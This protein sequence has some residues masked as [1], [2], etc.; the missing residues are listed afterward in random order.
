MKTESVEFAEDRAVFYGADSTVGYL[1]L[2][3]VVV[4][5]ALGVAWL[6]PGPW[7]ELWSP[8]TRGSWGIR[9]SL[10]LTALVALT[11]C[12][13]VVLGGWFGDLRRRH[14]IEID[15]AALEVRV[16]EWW[17]AEEVK[18][19]FPF[20]IFDEFAV[21]TPV[22][23][24]RFS[25]LGLVLH[26]G[27]YWRLLRSLDPDEMERRF[28][29]LREGVEFAAG[30]P[31]EGLRPPP[32]ITE[33]REGGRYCLSW[34]ARERTLTR[35]LMLVGA[36]FFAWASLLPVVLLFDGP[37]WWLA[38]VLVAGI[39]AFAGPLFVGFGSW[40]GWPLVGA[41]V[42]LIVASVVGLGANWLFYPLATVGAAIFGRNAVYMGRN[43]W[44]GERRSVSIDGEDRILCGQRVVVDG[45]EPV[46][47]DQ[48]EGVLVNV[49]QLRPPEFLLA[50]PG[51]GSIN[52]RR[53]L[54]QPADPVEPPTVD[55][56]GLSL[57]E[58][59]WVSVALDEELTRRRNDPATTEKSR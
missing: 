12:L 7:D 6:W 52:R 39:A 9:D 37:Q 13:A 2:A 45:G 33:E 19:V 56:S 15:G 21:H 27:A 23:E 3:V 50:R 11:G 1:V 57:F 43:L 41:W 35:G 24:Q 58:Q 49:T 38:A 22:G 47:V 55:I 10:V 54:G 31:N 34:P 29:Q 42:V 20:R 4:T 17:R 46:E 25:E 44:R 53:H 14:W 48:V 8:W 59:V 32:R 26:S 18:V 51:Q 16:R 5:T 28:E 40:T 36:I 30:D